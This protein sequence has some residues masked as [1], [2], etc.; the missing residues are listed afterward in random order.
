MD[1]RTGRTPLLIFDGDCGFCTSSAQF[2]ARRWRA[3]PA[4]AAVPWQHLDGD[5]MRALG[6]TEAQVQ[7][8]AFW[9]DTRGRASSGYEAVARALMATGGWRRLAGEAILHT[10]LSWLARPGYR[11]VSRYRHLLPG[12]TPACRP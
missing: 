12:G 1:E 11:L 5:E 9:V 6:L 8:A 3:R 7:E 10:P 4:P 2:V